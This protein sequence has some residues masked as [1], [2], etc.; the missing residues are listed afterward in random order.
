MNRICVSITSQTSEK[1]RASGFTDDLMVLATS[2][3][4]RCAAPFVVGERDRY[5]STYA[6]SPETHPT[7]QL[8]QNKCAGELFGSLLIAG[9]GSRVPLGS[10]L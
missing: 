5:Q 3:T 8:V 1:H 10:C 2:R 4:L 9:S 6:T 7:G